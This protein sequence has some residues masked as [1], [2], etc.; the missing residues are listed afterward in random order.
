[1]ELYH[2]SLE[3]VPRP[4]YGKGRL[5][6][7]F[8]QG[9]YCTDEYNLACE[10][11]CDGISAH[12]FANRYRLDEAGLSV[13]DFQALSKEKQTLAWA[14]TL[15]AYRQVNLT[16]GISTVD[17]ERFIRAYAVDCSKFDLVRGYRADDSYF[18]IMRAFCHSALSLE[19][20]G[21]TLHLG[22]L[23][24]QIVLKSRKAFNALHFEGASSVDA[25]H[26]GRKRNDRNRQATSI[27]LQMVDD[28]ERSDSETYFLD[29]ARELTRK[30]HC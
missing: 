2:G 8:G 29:I 16:S 18:N 23:G 26:W 24:T 12:G 22:N 3:R 30:E 4:E 11:A 5:H 28:I 17:V 19:N 10:W 25:Q 1:M 20:L 27:F 15:M 21:K 14:A 9:F 6:N 13:F 7:D